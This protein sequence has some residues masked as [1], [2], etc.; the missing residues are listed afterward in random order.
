MSAFLPTGL[1]WLL[2]FLVAVLV[3]ASCFAVLCYVFYSL[4]LYAIAKR[5]GLKYPGL[6]WVPAASEWVLGCTADQFDIVTTGKNMKLRRILLGVGIGF[7]I[8]YAI[9]MVLYF[10]F[11]GSF[12]MSAQYGFSF[13][14]M[15]FIIM[16]LLFPVAVALA[17]FQFIALYKL[18]RSCS[19]DNAVV[20]IVLSIIFSVIIPFVVFAIRKNDKGMPAVQAPAPQI[21]PV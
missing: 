19:P 17:V 8:V 9:Y 15:L 18:Y 3:F 11:M 12:W 4:G 21:P 10:D 20:L 16:F 5:R 7:Y 6:A 2:P 14:A 13:P 1:E